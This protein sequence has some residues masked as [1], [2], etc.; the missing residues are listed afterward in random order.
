MPLLEIVKEVFNLIRSKKI[1]TE[2]FP[3]LGGLPQ[4]VIDKMLE[5]ANDG[6][7]LYTPVQ[8]I[9]EEKAGMYYCLRC[10]SHGEIIG[11]NIVCLKCCNHN[12]RSFQNDSYRAKVKGDCRYVHLVDNYVVMQDF[13]WCVEENYE[14]GPFVNLSEK[15]RFI[16]TDN[17]FALYDANQRYPYGREVEVTWTLRKRAYEE[18]TKHSICFTDKSIL[19]HPLVS[20][21]KEFLTASTSEMA[22][23][24]TYTFATDK[25][26]SVDFP[27]VSFPKLD[28]SIIQI[29]GSWEVCSQFQ[30]VPGTQDFEKQICWCANCG[31]YHEQIV[32]T[33]YTRDS[34]KCPK[35]GY[36]RYLRNP[37]NII[38]DGVETEDGSALLKIHGVYKTRDLEGDLIV[39]V[40]PKVKENYRPEYTEYVLVS[41]EGKITFFNEGGKEM[42]RMVTPKR[43]YEKDQEFYFS[44]AATELIKNSKAIKRTGYAEWKDKGATPRYFEY[45]KGMPCL[46]IF[47]KMGMHTLVRDVLSKELSDI[48]QYI[49]KTGKDSRLSKLSKPQINSLRK[50]NAS[51][52][53]LLAYMRVL[54]RDEEVLFEDFNDVALRSHERHILDIMCVGVP[55]MTVARI[56]DYMYRVDDAQCCS[57]SESMQL[58]ADYLRMLRDLEADLTDTKLVFPNSLKREHD[59]ASRKVQ[60]LQNEKLKERFEKK[61]EENDWL[62]YKGKTLSAVIPH[63]MTELY[64]EGR[65]L[66]HCVGTYAKSVA[67]GASIIAFVRKNSNTNEP[68]C[69]VEIRG[70]NIVQAKGFANRQGV[71][72][73]GVKE[74]LNEW[75]KEKKLK[76]DVA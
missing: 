69:T 19:E 43:Q 39:G 32:S 75:S 56:R 36:S 33:R 21:I 13:H 53:H 5:K 8:K 40:N 6:M 2:V 23:V 27:D 65:K 60:Q 31:E 74:F 12:V 66:N 42:E 47:S 44:E 4:P 37:L 7:L 67:D 10:G 62:A 48:P 29:P 58:W 41:P 15:A 28:Y 20:K 73:P 54:N 72:F 50:S 24:L 45:L 61:A 25:E 49:R 51:L 59:K 18:I 3:K 68:Y 52:K 70:K 34:D 76:L 71:L 16:V 30:V 17:D 57:P 22:K 14:K 1:M 26:K 9:G 46:E 63:Q 11:E 38:I 64:E 55:G 35:C